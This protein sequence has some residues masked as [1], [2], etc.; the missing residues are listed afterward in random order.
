MWWRRIPGRVD[1]V[2]AKPGSTAPEADRLTRALRAVTPACVTLESRVSLDPPVV[3]RVRERLSALAGRELTVHVEVNPRL[4]AGALLTVGA[5]TRVTLDPGWTFL[6]ELEQGI[7]LVLPAEVPTLAGTAQQLSRAVAHGPPA[8]RVEDLAGRGTVLQV[9]DGV[10]FVRGLEGVGSQEVVRFEAGVHGL[11]F[12]LG[13]EVVG[14]LLLGPE[15]R[16]R[17][18]GAV[19]RTGE[20]LRVPVG[21]ALIG[22]IV[23]ALGRPIDGG[24]PIA[25]ERQ[26]PIE[27]IA[28]GVVE[29]RPVTDSLHTGI[30]MIDALVPLGRGQRELVLGDRQ[31]G[32]T[33][34]GL[35][36]ILSQKDTGVVC[37][38]AAIG[39]KASTLARVVGLLEERGAMEYTIVVAALAG[40]PPAFRHVAPYAACAMAEDVMRRGGNALSSHT[41]K[42]AVTYREISALLKRPIGREA[43]PG[44]IF[45][46]HSRLLERAARLR[47]DLGGGSLTA[48]PIVQTL[49]GDL[50][51]LI[52]TNV[53]SICDGQIFLD[54]ALFNDG[55]RPAMDVG[56]SVSRVGGMAQSPAMRKVAGRLRIDL[57]QYHEMA[58]FV[59]FGAEVDDATLEQ[60]KRGER[61]LELLKQGMH[62]PLPL[63]HEIVV[64]YAAVHGYTDDLPVDRLRA[65]EARLLEYM[66]REHPEVM[67]LIRN[68]RDLSTEAERRL[69]AALVAFREVF[70][71]ESATAEKATG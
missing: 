44:D 48:L 13:E 60:L 49:A 14:C 57:A 16:I 62:M 18:G 64:L 38:Y 26:S 10:A 5:D 27:A 1:L 9:G 51:A 4:E 34:I 54:T 68:T 61:E 2:A 47:D 8:L 70:A 31:I 24:A 59:K 22:R 66:A 53:I 65:F 35:D 69:A 12:N 15:E 46:V 58:R 55:F 71:R 20:Q 39:Q 11:A 21:D 6:E 56:L 30:K 42:H 28:P 67:A 3:E 23:D 63:D 32:K 33:T 41:S 40:E 37:V 7:G 25:C 45:Y 19:E 43:Y 29:R 50:S 17:E 36:A 52:P